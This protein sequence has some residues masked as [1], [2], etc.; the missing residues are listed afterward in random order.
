MSGDESVDFAREQRFA[1]IG[2][3][4]NPLQWPHAE[5]PPF[6]PKPV[7]LFS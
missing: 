1:P 7:A 2:G 3:A 6:P 4:A 5:K